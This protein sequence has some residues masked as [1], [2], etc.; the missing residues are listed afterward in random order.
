MCPVKSVTHVPGCTID[1]LAVSR[2][3]A[4]MAS[5]P[6]RGPDG[7]E[8]TKRPPM[9]IDKVAMYNAINRKA[10]RPYHATKKS[11][12]DDTVYVLYCAANGDVVVMY[13]TRLEFWLFDKNGDVRQIDP[14]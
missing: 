9:Q 8:T 2:A 1:A 4:L 12:A 3:P 11:V 14:Q 10:G 5:C 13:Y 7:H 6:T